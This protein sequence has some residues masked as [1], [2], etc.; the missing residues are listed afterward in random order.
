MTCKCTIGIISFIRPQKIN[1][2]FKHH[3]KQLQSAHTSLLR[4]CGSTR[5]GSLPQ[6]RV[7]SLLETGQPTASTQTS[8]SPLI[9]LMY[10]CQSGILRCHLRSLLCCVR[11]QL[12]VYSFIKCQFSLF[13]VMTTNKQISG[14][15]LYGGISKSIK[16]NGLKE[17]YC[18]L[19]PLKKWE[20]LYS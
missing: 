1:A 12:M 3:V 6:P 14:Y 15:K 10:L 16:K 18:G 17:S 9:I 19:L 2:L 8:S 20:K 13:L 11:T 4:L 7:S 5:F